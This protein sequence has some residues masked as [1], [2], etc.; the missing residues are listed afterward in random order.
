MTLAP[1]SRLG[2]YE[3]RAQIGEGGMGV[4]YRA[5]DTRLGREV[6]VKVLPPGFA[7]DAGRM[8]RFQL[9][10]RAVGNLSHPNI[11]AIFD[12]G[13][14]EGAPYLVMELLEGETL[15]EKLAGGR[16]LPP[17]RA[18]E[19]TLQIA[20]GLSAAHEQGVV[21]RDLKPEN[22]FLTK[23]GR[24]KIL[25]F[26]LAK[27]TRLPEEALD[28]GTEQLTSPL[29]GPGTEAGILVG[30][31]GYMS[32]EQVSGK[33]VDGRSD[34]FCLGV[35]LWEML[36][37]RHP[38]RGESVVE[39]L[40]AILKQEPPDL[41]ADLRIPPLLERVIQSCLAKSPA[42]RFHSAHDLA[43]ALE[44]AA[45]G[46]STS[47][48]GAGISGAL[49]RRRFRPSWKAVL[50]GA[51]VLAA[52]AVLGLLGGRSGHPQPSF[53][54]L[55]FAPGIVD[56]AFFSPDGRSVYFCGRFQG[57]APLVFLRSPES[58]D[59]R[60]VDT[61][62][63]VLAAVSPANELAV[64]REARPSTDGFQ[65]IL[66]QTTGAGGSL[67]DLQEDVLEAAWDP[68]GRNLAAIVADEKF[69]QRVEYPL[70][71]VLHTSIGQLKYLRMSRPGGRIALVEGT[72]GGARVLVLEGGKPARA[73]MTKAEDLFAATLTGLAWHPKEREVWVSE[74]Q[75][76]QTTFWALKLD[77]SRRM[78]WRGPGTVRL[79]DLAADGRALVTVQ[80]ARKG[81]FFQRK[82]DPSPRDLSVLDGTQALAFLPDGRLLLRE[83][84]SLDGGTLQDETYLRKADGGPPLRLA[85]GNPRSLSADGRYVGLS[86]YDPA[87]EES[88]GMTFVP[89]G[90]GRSLQVAL[91]REFEGADDW[92][93]FQNGRKVLFAGMEKGKNWRF[94]VLDRQGGAPR[95]FTPEGVR[96]PK[97]LLLS[98][99]ETTL[100]GRTSAQGDY[101][102]FPLAG[103]SPRPIRGLLPTETP[104]GWTSDGRGIHVMGRSSDLPVRIFRVDPETGR[105]QPAATF[106]PPDTA[107]YLGTEGVCLAPGGGALAV[108]YDRRVGDLYL[109][110]GLR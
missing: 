81:V 86:V 15:R 29:G 13:D 107:G 23:D 62:G 65:G 92:V 67:R 73:I 54:R 43:F 39:T 79:L 97:P 91:P 32:P 28:T 59:P 1:G 75:G 41:E 78:L 99:D 96:A 18:V 71:K 98:P 6:A 93:L 5:R 22:I 87:T 101:V 9:E 37:G 17:K 34:L 7:A 30:T 57:L 100:I 35:I 45:L 53:Q 103:G 56:S 83:S 109:M 64:L 27:S 89:T 70:G 66:A 95:P 11:L 33:P 110:E 3:I 51:A 58:P 63:A 25:D 90:A 36:T 12:I 44:A 68:A 74:L 46:A 80:Q 14:D 2:P 84:P 38:F 106:T 31:V 47:L 49:P 82:D 4:V 76:N 19:I 77:G 55:T 94:Y 16:P 108:T 102:L 50:A 48:S 105:R 20:Q 104:V 42:G 10:A 26:G 40:H 52:G 61:Q 85:K 24:V 69:N 60:P 72:G 21:H 88:D 8:R